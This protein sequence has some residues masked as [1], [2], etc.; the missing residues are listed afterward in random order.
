MRID[1]VTMPNIEVKPIER[2]LKVLYD[3]CHEMSNHIM[4]MSNEIE[5]LKD[6]IRYLE[7]R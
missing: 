3:H 6:K 4:K 1:S 5:D 7:N 2:A